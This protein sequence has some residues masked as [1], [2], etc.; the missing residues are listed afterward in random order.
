V[1]RPLT[2]L[3]SAPAGDPP[4]QHAEADSRK[5]RSTPATPAKER[6]L[7]PGK[8]ITLARVLSIGALAAAI[9]LVVAV[10]FGGD[11]GHTYKLRFETG[12]QLVPGNEVLVGGQRF[13][14]VD[15]IELT[16][17]NLAEIT[18][19]T[20]EPIRE[21]TRAVIRATSLS[22]VANHYMSLTLG[23]DNADPLPED[24]AVLG[25]D[26]TTTPVDLD[27]LFNT[28]DRRTRKGLKDVIQGFAETYAGK[29]EAANATYKYFAPSLSATDRLL[30]EIDRDEAVFTRFIVDTSKVV[31]AVAERR[32]DLTDLVSNTNAALGAIAA[33]NA[34]FDASLRLLPPTLRQANTTFVNLRAALDDLDPLVNTTKR[35][36]RG[37]KPF[38]QELRPVAR[39]AV[40]VFADLSLTVNRP[41]EA[42]DLAELV[43]ALPPLHRL[44]SASTRSSIRAM[45][46]S[47]EN[48]AFARAY[49]PDLWGSFAKLGQVTGY[50]D[51]DGHYAR[52]Q[53][54]AFNLFDY[55]ELTGNLV[56]IPPQNK[57]DGFETE[58]STRCPGGATQPI[59][60]SNPFLD[61]GR[62]SGKCD[63]SDVPPGP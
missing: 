31:T 57:F 45:N 11:D 16:E 26:A 37:L 59:P 46:A 47:E 51:G 62:L 36:T 10:L 25:L 42:N 14:L 6:R 23:P 50:Y 8:G 22:G 24:E 35:A 54:A 27:Q 61:D 5:G 41:G 44:A 18:I 55:D 40:P 48:I 33:Q 3:G 20:D 58:I 7:S 4:G 12:G 29:G 49:A 17:D 19:T 2:R 63:P 34:S 39:R 30:R 52:V 15:S 32:N 9:A 56:P 53:A 38:L 1:R 60:G 13:G 28:F 21:G 43:T